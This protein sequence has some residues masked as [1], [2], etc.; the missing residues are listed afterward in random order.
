LP[1]GLFPC[2][3]PKC[4]YP[5]YTLSSEGFPFPGRVLPM[6]CHSQPSLGLGLSF[7][8]SIPPGSKAQIFGRKQLRLF[9]LSG[10]IVASCP[11]QQQYS[12]GRMASM[13]HRPPFALTYSSK[14]LDS[15]PAASS[16]CGSVPSQCL[17]K[18][19]PS[20]EALE[21]SPQVEIVVGN[22]RF[23]CGSARRIDLSPQL[24]IEV[25]PRFLH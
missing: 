19:F 14:S 7:G 3:K 8:S 6:K 16:H 23:T 15:Q 18:L 12:C 9:G 5:R 20:S 25:H 1:A 22:D 17:Q 2:R 21:F 13:C 11:C 24:V 4:L 10:S